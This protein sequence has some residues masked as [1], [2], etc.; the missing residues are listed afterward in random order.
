MARLSHGRI[1]PFSSVDLSNTSG[2]RDADHDGTSREMG[3]EGKYSCRVLLEM[4]DLVDAY[5]QLCD[6]STVYFGGI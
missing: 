2:S 3:I 4:L 6:L 5:H 1:L